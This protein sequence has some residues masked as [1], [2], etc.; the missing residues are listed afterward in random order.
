MLSAAKHLIA[1]GCDGD[2]AR[3]EVFGGHLWLA[4]MRSFAPRANARAGQAPSLA[5]PFQNGAVAL[6]EFDERIHDGAHPRQGPEVAVHQQPL[7]CEDLGDDVADAAKGGVLVTEIARQH[8]E[9]R[10]DAHRV[11]QAKAAVVPDRRP[12]AERAMRPSSA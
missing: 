6:E 12:P 11:L 7:L 8:G 4:A 5:A 1:S 10:P 3:I 9:A 2:R